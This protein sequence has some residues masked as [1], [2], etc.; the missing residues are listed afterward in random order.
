MKIAEVFSVSV[1]GITNVKCVSGRS[2]RINEETC[3][4]AKVTV[5]ADG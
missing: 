3:K 4:A 5:K 1:E 2:V